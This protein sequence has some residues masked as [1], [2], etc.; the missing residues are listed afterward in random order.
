MEAKR[1]VRVRQAERQDLPTLL[2][3]IHGLAEYEKL[4]PP[5]AEAL[6]RL[7]AHGWPEDGTP[8]LFSAWLAEVDIDDAM[9]LEAVGY[10][11]TF[12]TYSSFLARPT[13]YIEDIFILP[14]KRRMG[15]GYAL[16]QHLIAHARNLGCGRVEWV[17]LDWNVDAQK[18]YQRI[19]AEHL[20][21]WFHYR[22]T[23]VE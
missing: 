4:P 7:Q 13:L 11:I 8:P 20:Y 18:F 5:D 3:L 1:T 14:E 19:G 22:L 9:P 15:A 21:E 10:A 16:I 23:L 17:V 2:R 12:F 6:A